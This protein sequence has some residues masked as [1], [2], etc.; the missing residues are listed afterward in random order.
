[1]LAAFTCTSV[2]SRAPAQSDQE[3]AGARA[4]A[5]DGAQ[6]YDEKRWAD[7]VDLFTRA[8]SLVHA[9]PHWL[10]IAR[11]QTRLGHWV[12]AREAY[13]KIIRENIADSAP[14]AFREAQAVAKKELPELEPRIPT[15]TVRVSG[16]PGKTPVVS[17][18]GQPLPRALIGA[19]NP[20]DPGVHKISATADGMASP[21]ATVTLKEGA[22]ETITLTL[23]PSKAAETPHSGP[24]VPVEPQKKSPSPPAGRSSAAVTTS[25]QAVPATGTERT[26]PGMRAA[27]YAAL[28][29]GIVGVGFGSFFALRSMSKRS[30]GDDI[31]PNAKRC[32]ISE[33][34]KVEGLDDEA[35]RAQ[36]LST[37]G[38]IAGGVGV[39]SFVTLFLLS[40]HR[41]ETVPSAR[42]SVHVT[43]FIGPFGT[44][45]HGTF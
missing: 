29:V 1:M 17:V 11:S 16:G 9:P 18:D 41:R 38:F 25:K 8:E 26:S 3:R 43:P 4:L 45:L 35:G 10:M 6:A 19:S 30:Q 14:K 36:T 7:A 33:R 12:S 27:S 37:V 21:V 42:A 15:L 24:V 40:H 23:V 22:H 28:G 44:G 39:A 31:C 20:T 34:D 32:P 5:N 13:L 2:A